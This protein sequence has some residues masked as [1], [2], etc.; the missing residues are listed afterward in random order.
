M[1]N[2][3]IEQHYN[4]LEAVNHQLAELK[5]RKASLENDIIQN[6]R[7]EFEHLLREKDEPFGKVNV[8]FGEFDMHYTVPKKVQWNQE[9]LAKIREKIGQFEN[10]DQ[11]IKVKYDVSETAFKNW[12]D[13]IKEVFMPAR[14][15]CNGSAKIEIEKYKEQ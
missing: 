7:D 4:E 15:V 8:V 2:F 6:F 9:K 12:P 10:P 5:N 1:K 14:T 3:D 13:D 11:Y